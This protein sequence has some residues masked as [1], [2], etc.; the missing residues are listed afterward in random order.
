MSQVGH[1]ATTWRR[2]RGSFF[3]ANRGQVLASL[4]HSAP[5]WAG[6]RPSSQFTI[7]AT[8]SRSPKGRCRVEP[9]VGR[10]DGSRL[11][12]MPVNRDHPCLVLNIA[13]GAKG[14]ATTDPGGVIAPPFL[15]RKGPSDDK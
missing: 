2:R 10:P 12:C 6:T 7:G 13:D 5:L 4:W 14:E 8:S 15:D 11:R 3:A 9:E 1:C